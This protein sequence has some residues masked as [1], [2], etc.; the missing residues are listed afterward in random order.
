M[1]TKRENQESKKWQ[2]RGHQREMGKQL[3]MG[4][5]CWSLE[6]FKNKTLSQLHFQ[7]SHKIKFHRAAESSYRNNMGIAS[8]SLPCTTPSYWEHPALSHF[9]PLCRLVFL[10]VTHC[11][12][13]L[14]P[15]WF[16]LIP[17]ERAPRY[18][19]HTQEWWIGSRVHGSGGGCGALQCSMTD[20]NMHY[21]PGGLHRWGPEC[22]ILPVHAGPAVQKKGHF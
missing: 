2:K 9:Y 14:L 3:T 21:Y 20:G 22:S 6:N 5:E 13:V 19:H 4:T 11:L 18:C 12:S 17:L 1:S 8:C 7:A 10:F 15:F 16:F